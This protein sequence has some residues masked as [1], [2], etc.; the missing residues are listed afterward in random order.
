MTFPPLRGCDTGSFFLFCLRASNLN[1]S[2]P[3]HLPRIPQSASNSLLNRSPSQPCGGRVIGSPVW[4]VVGWTNQ[5]PEHCSLPFPSPLLPPRSSRDWEQHFFFTGCSNCSLRPP[6]TFLPLPTTERNL[7]LTCHSFLYRVIGPLPI[8][9][10]TR[11]SLL[12][13]AV[14]NMTQISVASSANLHVGA[15]THHPG[16]V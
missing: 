6:L 16:L 7:T 10:S 1:S 11:G 2:N 8:P 14:V 3:P 9:D 12:C 4:C 13:G 15:M 5:K